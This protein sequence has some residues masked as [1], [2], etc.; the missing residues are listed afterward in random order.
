MKGPCSSPFHSPAGRAV[1]GWVGVLRV[2]FFWLPEIWSTV[3]Y[4][5]FF[6][7]SSIIFSLF[8]LWKPN[9]SFSS[10]GPSCVGGRV[11]RE[12]MGEYP[13]FLCWAHTLWRGHCHPASTQSWQRTENGERDWECECV[14]KTEKGEEG[15][16]FFLLIAFWLPPKTA[17][18][19]SRVT[20]S[21]LSTQSCM[22]I[23]LDDL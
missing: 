17:T 7:C 14:G 10:E 9:P 12:G 11:W 15:V 4:V 1:E 18:N 19:L 6:F 22:Q 21:L 23:Q 20:S 3:I 8:S 2:Q 16:V 13:Y 5:S